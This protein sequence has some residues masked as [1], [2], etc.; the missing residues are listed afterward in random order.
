M[1]TVTSVQPQGKF[2]ALSIEESG[3]VVSFA[4]KPKGDGAWI[5]G[6]FFVMESDVFDYIKNG[7]ETILEREPM[8]SLAEAGQLQAYKYSG[9][10]RAMDTLKDKNDLTAL[11]MTGNAPWALWM[12]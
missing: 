2:G 6:G 9:F 8:E 12:K 1:V 7:D 10:W 5:N 3:K 11:W 4:E